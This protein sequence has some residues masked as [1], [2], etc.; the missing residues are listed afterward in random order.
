[1]ELL[2][3]PRVKVDQL[4]EVRGQDMEVKQSD[5]LQVHCIVGWGIGENLRS[6]DLKAHLSTLKRPSSPLTDRPT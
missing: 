3:S 5:V 4:V 2:P 1:M 6:Q